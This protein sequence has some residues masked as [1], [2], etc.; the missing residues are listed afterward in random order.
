MLKQKIIKS[1]VSVLYLQ[2]EFYQWAQKSKL[3]LLF[4]ILLL[5]A[6]LVNKVTLC[7]KSTFFT[8]KIV[9]FVPNYNKT[10]S[11]CDMFM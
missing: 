5:E 7:K 10:F 6:I 3:V 8:R 9:D 4:K 2:T 11:L 1:A